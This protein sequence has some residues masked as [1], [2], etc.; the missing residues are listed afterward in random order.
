MTIINLWR[1]FYLKLA[2]ILKRD[3]T[4]FIIINSER[5]AITLDEIA[6]ETGL[7]LPM[8]LEQFLFGEYFQRLKEVMG[9]LTFVND[10]NEF[11]ILPPI[12]DSF[13]IICLAFNYIDQPSWL[14]FGKDPPKEPVISLKPRTS[15]IG[16]MDD[17]LCPKFVK[18]L[19]YEGELALVIGKKC[20]KVAEYDALKYVSGY[21]VLNDISARDLQFADKQY[22]RAK[23]FDTFG[24]CGPWL[25]TS[26]EIPDP[27]NLHIT[28]NVNGE[29]RQNSS[30][31]NLVLKID[32]IISSMSKVMTL[33][34][35]YQPALQVGLPY[36]FHQV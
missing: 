11:K 5:K 10:L 20:R 31:K 21:F 22:T 3:S 35:E 27:N 16:P 13:K 33:E 15:L 17:I 19:D 2:R 24:P 25:T 30:T 36:L 26:D 9:K 14:R 12:I 28:T 23:G 4:S 1:Y 34:P 6:K 7:T 18:Q 32:K 8:N 29:I